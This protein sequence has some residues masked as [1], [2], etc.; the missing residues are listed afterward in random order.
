MNHLWVESLGYLL[1]FIYSSSGKVYHIYHIISSGFAYGTPTP[2]IR[3]S[4]AL[5]KV[6]YRLNIRSL[7]HTSLK[8][9]AAI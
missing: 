8:I 4:E 6:K 3:S 1:I 2:P 5:Y 9:N 7:V